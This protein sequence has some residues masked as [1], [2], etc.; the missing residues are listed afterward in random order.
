MVDD[1]G[2]IR[3]KNRLAA[4]QLAGHWLVPQHLA[5]IGRGNPAPIG[6]S[7][8]R[9]AQESRFINYFA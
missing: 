7:I 6:K 3:Q 8:D 1:D 5:A 2:I 4:A 9:H